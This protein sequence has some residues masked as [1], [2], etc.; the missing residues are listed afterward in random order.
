MNDLYQFHPV[1]SAFSTVKPL[2]P[3][4]DVLILLDG[5]RIVSD[6]FVQSEPTPGVYVVRNASYAAVL[7]G[8]RKIELYVTDSTKVDSI[9]LGLEHTE[10]RKS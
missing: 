3:K 6:G 8:T 5:E 2:D 4:V 7:D 10:S 9:I 1:S